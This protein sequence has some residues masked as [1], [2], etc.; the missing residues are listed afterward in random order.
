MNQEIASIVQVY[1]DKEAISR[2]VATQTIELI[3]S[4]LSI[5]PYVSI[6]LAGGSTPKMLYSL[7]ATEFKQDIPWDKLLVFWGDERYVPRDHE[8]S[9]YLMAKEA[10][11]DHVD[12]PA[13]QVFPMPTQPTNPNDGAA[14]YAITLKEQLAHT[15]GRFDLVLLGMGDDGHTASLFPG[16]PAL[17]EEELMVVAA[18]A[19]VDPKQRLTLTYPAINNARNIYF[20]VA[21]ADKAPGL[22]CAMEQ[23][24]EITVCPSGEVDPLDGNLI[25][26]VDQA[27][28]AMLA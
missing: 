1:K 24:S 11:L 6:A 25:W 17:E 22:C 16:S 14:S 18:P 12:T 21:G 8:K 7:L 23:A 15:D 9:N 27:A 26:F 2:Q 13:D 20:L 4:T 28:A 10:M 19:P 3:N 5:R